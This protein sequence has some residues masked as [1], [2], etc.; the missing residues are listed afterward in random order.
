MKQ[1][2]A[3]HELEFALEAGEKGFFLHCLGAFLSVCIL[4]YG[5]FDERHTVETGRI[6]KERYLSPSKSSDRNPSAKGPSLCFSR[7]PVQYSIG[8]ENRRGL[9]TARSVHLPNKKQLG[10]RAGNDTHLR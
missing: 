3:E 10:R 6:G 1:Q 7:Y 8:A 2:L 4:R 9:H 5:W